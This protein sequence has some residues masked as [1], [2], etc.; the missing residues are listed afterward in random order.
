MTDSQ[1]S[2][3]NEI[4]PTPR[5]PAYIV[6][7]DDEAKPSRK[8]C[9][10]GIGGAIGCAVIL[11][12]IPLVLIALGVTSVSGLL[13]GIG[14]L[15]GV[16]EPPRAQVIST[17]TI[18]E[19]IQPLA[20]LVVYRAELAKADVTVNVYQG[21]FNTCGFSADHVVQGAV[22]AG[23][24]LSKIDENSMSYDPEREVY[25]LI[26][27]E[28]QLTSCRIDFIRQYARS[29]TTCSVD[30]DE[31]RLL[32]NYTAL[33]DFR[34]D[35]LEGDFLEAAERQAQLVIG[36]FVQAVTGRP[37][38]IVFQPQENVALPSSCDPDSPEG[39]S[40]DPNSTV[41]RK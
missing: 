35:A 15:F 8:G 13:G 17:R 36:N 4:T 7:D 21:N 40:Y 31:A 6:A 20:Q 28:P 33:R 32:A 30:W 18:I 11:L 29:F 14:G 1:T 9:L 19:G 3:P 27:P 22:E 41:W 2:P 23:V 10:W 25:V 5:E 38:Q 37:V 24:D 39:W 34:D 12:I 26:V 16:G